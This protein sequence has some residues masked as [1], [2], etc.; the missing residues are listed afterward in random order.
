MKLGE[1]YKQLRTDLEMAEALYDRWD[2]GEIAEYIRR[3]YS[4]TSV[5]VLEALLDPHPKL[6]EIIPDYFHTFAR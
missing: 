3:D 5:E 6:W 2:T 1:R 4:E